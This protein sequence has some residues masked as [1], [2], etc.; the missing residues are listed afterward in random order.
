MIFASDLDRTLIYSKR[1][2]DEFGV[3]E[4]LILVPV[5]QKDGDSVAFMTET[6]YI[7][8]KELA[9]QSLFVP[10]TTRTTDQFKRFDIFEQD[11]SIKYAITANGANILHQGTMMEEWSNQILNRVKL[12]TVSQ[13]ELLSTLHREGVCL[14]GRR[15]QAEGWFFYF[16]L[17]CL[18]SNNERKLIEDLAAKSGWRISL[19]GRKLYFI[20]Q[21]ISKG[22]AL[23]Y[24]CKLEGEN[25][26]AG[27]GDSLLDW[28][29]LK[30]CQYRFVPNHGELAHKLAHVTGGSTSILST[31][32]G[33]KAGEE[34]IQHF[35]QLM[36]TNPIF[37]L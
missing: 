37:L 23:E 15:K 9:N 22:N 17:N 18:P 7:Q 36:H 24:I 27:A 21:A 34:I 19:Q 35:H 11:I 12:E 26:V 31:N 25:S 1:A 33:V 3:P 4:G 14:D 28:D 30:N 16:L 20:P 13:T 8:L 32:S 10:V 5:E 29:F 6:S 2:L